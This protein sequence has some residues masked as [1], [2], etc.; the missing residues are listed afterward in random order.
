MQ[1][2][3]SGEAV[4]SPE[5]REQGVALFDFGGGTTDLAVFRS[6]AIKHTGVL[7]LGGNNMTTDLAMGLRCTASRRPNSI[8]KRYGSALAMVAP[9]GKDESHNRGGHGRRQAPG[10]GQAAR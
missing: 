3:A 5:E 7:A 6:Q 2:L 4:L 8:K 10:P 9:I 1:S